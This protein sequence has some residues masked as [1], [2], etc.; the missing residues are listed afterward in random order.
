MLGRI[1]MSRFTISDLGLPVNNNDAVNKQF[2]IYNTSVIY[3]YG[4]INSRGIA[5]VDRF[6]LRMEKAYIIS[7]GIY[8]S[9]S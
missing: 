9:V 7:F 8:S 3:L 6:D 4:L 1:S 5:Y 2:I